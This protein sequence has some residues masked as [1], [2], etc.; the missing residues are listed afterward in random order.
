MAE[1][2]TELEERKKEESKYNKVAI[3]R[4][5]LLRV[6]L[7]LRLSGACWTTRLLTLTLILLRGLAVSFSCDISSRKSSTIRTYRTK[8]FLTIWRGC[9]KSS[10]SFCRRLCDEADA[11]MQHPK[12]QLFDFNGSKLRVGRH[13]PRLCG[14][15]VY[16]IS[17]SVCYPCVNVRDACPNNV[18]DSGVEI[19]N[20]WVSKL[21]IQREVGVRTNEA[22]Y[23]TVYDHPKSRTGGCA[24]WP[25]KS[26]ELYAAGATHCKAWKHRP[27]HDDTVPPKQ[28]VHL[29]SV[30]LHVALHGLKG[31]AHFVLASV[32]DEPLRNNIL[33][34][35]SAWY[36]ADMSNSATHC[37]LI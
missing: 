21:W 22:K 28:L 12:A 20:V 5:A 14:R 2:L 31:I 37:F 34:T 7:D 32:F 35:P 8:T 18:V 24:D 15:I 29:G 27:L 16:I 11:R 33:N 19:V 36:E 17:C 13:A 9:R 4:K 25:L 23:A 1:K 26:V 6:I 10:P 3:R 30:R